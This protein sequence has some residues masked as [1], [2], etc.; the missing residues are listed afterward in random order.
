MPLMRKRELD[1]LVRREVRQMQGA[2]VTFNA[3]KHWKM[4]LET[5]GLTPIAY[6]MA[7]EYFK[8]HSPPGKVNPTAFAHPIEDEETEAAFAAWMAEPA[9]EDSE[10]AQ[11]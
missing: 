2:G 6:T 3:D 10:T 11:E 8:R 7:A 4:V 9:K 1:E 5:P